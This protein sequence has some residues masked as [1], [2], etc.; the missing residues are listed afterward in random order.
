MYTIHLF[1][2][3][4]MLAFPVVGLISL[5]YLLT[6]ACLLH[7]VAY[8]VVAAGLGLPVTS[9]LAGALLYIVLGMF[10]PLLLTGLLVWAVHKM[11]VRKV[12]LIDGAYWRN[13]FDNLRIVI[14]NPPQWTQADGR[15]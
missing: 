5:L 13:R 10:E 4:C 12:A 1:L 3:R 9:L 15:W 6:P 2:R 11:V 14:N 8:V 7:A